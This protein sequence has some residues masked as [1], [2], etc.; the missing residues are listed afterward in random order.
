MVPDPVA[1]Q[2]EPAVAPPPAPKANTLERL[3]ELDEMK[4]RGLISEEEFQQMRRR[5]IDRF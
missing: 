1:N 2:A 5:V 3:E 4:Q